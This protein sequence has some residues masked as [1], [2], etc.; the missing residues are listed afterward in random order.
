METYKIEPYGYFLALMA[1]L[2]TFVAAFAIL[3]GARGLL[4]VVW[5]GIVLFF[6]WGTLFSPFEA[7]IRPD[8]RVELRRLI[9]RRSVP[10]GEIVAVEGL[11]PGLG[12]VLRHG[13]RRIWFR[14]P[15]SETVH[16]A[17]RLR[18]LNPAVST[19]DL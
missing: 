8:R 7:T 1:P 9:G 11:A 12:F 16:F 14:V 17:T 18:I 10:I 6:W 2:M 15:L 19:T 13:R 3:T 4:V 5:V